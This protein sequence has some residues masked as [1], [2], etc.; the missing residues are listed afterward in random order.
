MIEISGTPTSA[1]APRDAMQASLR[2]ARH[3]CP[4]CGEGKLYSSFLKVADACPKCGEELHHHRADDAPPYFTMLIVGHI[5]VAGVLAL[6]AA[7]EPEL[8]VHALLWGPLL[9]IMSLLLLPRITGAL[10]GLQ[11]ALRMH[12]FGG[13]PDAAEPP[14]AAHQSGTG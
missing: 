5:V 8:W 4:A 13:Q 12:G 6:A 14:P 2:G 7:F 10:V 3:T 1:P 9:L 11:W